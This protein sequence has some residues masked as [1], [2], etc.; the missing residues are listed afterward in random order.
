M[1]WYRLRYLTLSSNIDSDSR[2]LVE[3]PGTAAA[4]FNDD[5]LYISCVLPEWRTNINIYTRLLSILRRI[6]INI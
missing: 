1:S 5:V 2:L 3:T 6:D 4:V